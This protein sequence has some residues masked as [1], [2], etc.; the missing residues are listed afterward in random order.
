MRRFAKKIS[1]KILSAQITISFGENPIWSATESNLRCRIN[2]KG[3]SNLSARFSMPISSALVGFAL[4]Q[5]PE[6]VMKATLVGITAALVSVL[7][8]AYSEDSLKYEPLS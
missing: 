6:D 3:K 1:R 8:E 2:T 7:V 4:T 5:K